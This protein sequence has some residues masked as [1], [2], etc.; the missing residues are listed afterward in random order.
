MVDQ[1][2][3]SLILMAL[4]YIG[5]LALIIWAAWS[6][7]KTNQAQSIA[8]VKEYEAERAANAN[9][10]DNMAPDKLVE[11]ANERNREILSAGRDPKKG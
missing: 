7:H 6:Q 1:A 9:E 3:L 4:V 5:I 2:Q 10:I 11:L 8:L